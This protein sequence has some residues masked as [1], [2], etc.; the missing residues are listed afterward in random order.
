MIKQKSRAFNKDVYLLGIDKEGTKYWLEA[1]KWDCG[2][3][4][5]VGYVETYQRNSEPS[6][7]RDIDSHQHFNGMFFNK[8]Q[9]GYDEFKAFFT[10]TVLTKNEI[11]T[12]IELMKSLYTL[13]EYSDT[14]CRGGAHY[15]NNPCKEIIQNNSEY[16]RINKIV[17]PAVLFEVYKL[18]S[19]EGK[20]GA[21]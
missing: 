13:R 7:A 12:L 20:D 10:E 15:T 4:W 21:K 18:L 17:I 2:W 5:G 8:K 3:Y 11:W 9:N 6:R 16:D 1:G 14:I 19:P